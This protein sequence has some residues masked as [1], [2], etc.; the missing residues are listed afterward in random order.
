[1]LGACHWVESLIWGAE[2]EVQPFFPKEAAGSSLSVVGHYARSGVYG[3]SVLDFP[4]LFNVDIF[5]LTQCVG[6]TQPFPG[7]LSEGIKPHVSTLLV[8]LWEEGS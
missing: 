7:S 5:S 1:M 4:F 3:K 6:V 2:L 8:C